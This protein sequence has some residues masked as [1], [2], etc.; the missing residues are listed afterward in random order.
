MIGVGVVGKGV[1]DVRIA[2]S[3]VGKGVGDVRIAVSGEAGVCG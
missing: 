2:V 1:G 3:V